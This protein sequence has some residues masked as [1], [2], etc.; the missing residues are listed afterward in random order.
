MNRL[1]LSNWKRFPVEPENWVTSIELKS[2]GE[3]A[4]HDLTISILF[5]FI[6]H[7][8][9]EIDKWFLWLYGFRDLFTLVQS[10]TKTMFT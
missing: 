1:C 5:Y 4:Q 9:P 2:S 6:S 3:T 10:G 8:S 7:Q